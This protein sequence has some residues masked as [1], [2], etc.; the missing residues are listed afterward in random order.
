MKIERAGIDDLERLLPLV[1]A[2][3]RFYGQE[4]AAPQERAFVAEHLRSGRSVVFLARREDDAAAIGFVQLHRTWQT[5]LLGPVWILEDLFVLPEARREGVASALLEASLAFARAEGAVG[6]FLE[7][8]RDN[9]A[10]QALYEA[11]GW[12]REGRFLKYNAPL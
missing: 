11:G 1:A 7:T 3:R 2:Y 6:L 4:H 8:A 12:T 9:V 5:V 10:G